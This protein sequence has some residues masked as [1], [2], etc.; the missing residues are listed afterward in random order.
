MP[1]Q[2]YQ[3]IPFESAALQTITLGIAPPPPLPGDVS[4]QIK[5]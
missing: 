2:N 1:S 4:N 5:L 3:I